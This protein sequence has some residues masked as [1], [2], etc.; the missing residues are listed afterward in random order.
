MN[1][2]ATNFDTKLVRRYFGQLFNKNLD[3][4]MLA[5]TSGQPGVVS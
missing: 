3:V 5:D 2:K 1:V 4:M